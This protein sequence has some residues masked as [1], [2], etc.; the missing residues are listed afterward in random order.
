[1][2]L[3]AVSCILA[4]RVPTEVPH[5]LSGWGESVTQKSLCARERS[6]VWN[7]LVS[8]LV[9]PCWQGSKEREGAWE[10]RKEK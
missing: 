6:L 3:E 5:V 8:L 7:I 2:F 1:M 9:A 4:D 10:D